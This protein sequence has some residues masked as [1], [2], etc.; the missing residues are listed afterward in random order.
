MKSKSSRVVAL[1]GGAGAVTLVLGGVTLA[2]APS[3]SANGEIIDGTPACIDVIPGSTEIAFDGTDDTPPAPGEKTV[4][5]VTVSWTAS[6]LQQDDPDHPGD[7]TGGTVVDFTATGGTVR[8]VLVNVKTDGADPAS[9]GY[10]AGFFD[11]RPAGVTSGTGV[12]APVRSATGKYYTIGHL[13]FCVEKTTTTPTP[14]VSPSDSPSSSPS[15]SPSDSPTVSPSDSPTVSPSDSPSTSPS[16]SPTVSPSDTPSTSPSD[17]PS[18]SPSDTPS[19]PSDSP[20]ATPSDSPSVVPTDSPTSTSTSPVAVPTEVDAGQSGG[21][22][23]T[24]TITGHQSVWGL[25]LIMLGGVLV[26]AGILKSR[27]NRGHHAA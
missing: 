25:G 13:R 3:A 8:G 15:T 27:Q 10:A 14:P 2:L 17:T 22:K 5:G 4:D 7:Q 18:A 23:L 24:S 16:D 12:H 20:S 9:F 19:T 1:L 11:Y 6:T 21:L 26:F